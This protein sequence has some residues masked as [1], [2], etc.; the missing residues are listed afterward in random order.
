MMTHKPRT[1]STSLQLQWSSGWKSGF[2]KAPVIVESTENEMTIIENESTSESSSEKEVVNRR[3]IVESFPHSKFEPS[4]IWRNPHVQTILGTGALKA[5]Y[6]GPL[7]RTFE[8]ETCERFETPDGDF[9]DVEFTKGFSDSRDDKSVIILH[10]LES[11]S[12]GNLVT[13]FATAFVKKG[14][15]CC[16]FNFRSCSGVEN[17]YALVFSNRYCNVRFA[18]PHLLLSLL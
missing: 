17:R 18:T 14:F 9:F 1:N 5:K 8:V 11:N 6:F 7:V 15:S 12:K 10:G 3:S 2:R 13:S 16:L 4:F